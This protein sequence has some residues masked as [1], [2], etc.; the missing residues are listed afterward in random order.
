MRIV[1]RLRLHHSGSDA[2]ALMQDAVDCHHAIRDGVGLIDNMVTG[3]L[4]PASRHD[5]RA[6]LAD[7]RMLP[8]LEN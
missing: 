2:T 5:F 4:L 3:L 8:N 6:G 7:V 1:V